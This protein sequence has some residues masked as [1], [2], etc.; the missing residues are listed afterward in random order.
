MRDKAMNGWPLLVIAGPTGSGKSGL[1]VRAALQC[2]GEVVNCDSIQVYRHFDIGAAK[3]TIEERRG[4]PHHLIDVAEPDE[5]FTAGDYARLARRAVGEIRERGGVPIVCGGTGFYL[6]ALL[7]GLFEGPT[8]DEALRARLMEREGRR[9]GAL[10][11]ILRR[12][13]AAAAAR[14]HPNDLQKT[15]RAVEVC[16]SG[17]PTLSEHWAGGREALEGFDVRRVIL[18]PPRAEL[19]RRIGE[20]LEKMFE[21][22]LIEETERILAMG[23]GAESKPF[24]SLG[25]KQALGVAR[26]ALTRAEAIEEAK[27]ETR[28]YAKRQATWFRRGPGERMAGFGDEEAVEERVLFAARANRR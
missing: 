4:V 23:Y 25:Y 24:A 26:G 20:R 19:Y 8:R 11:R 10:H 14:I 9:K 12:L 7:D 2:G 27:R 3:L 22:G 15:L 16:L 5:L 18:E 1:A 6:R 28:H 13:D 17:R 21:G